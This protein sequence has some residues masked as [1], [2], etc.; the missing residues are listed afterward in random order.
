MKRFLAGML[1][2]LLLLAIA[3]SLATT[4][5]I[6]RVEMPGNANAAGG[7]FRRADVAYYDHRPVLRSG[8]RTLVWWG[9]RDGE[10]RRLEWRSSQGN[11]GTYYILRD[12]A[13][14]SAVGIERGSSKQAFFQARYDK[15]RRDYDA[16][17]IFARVWTWRTGRLR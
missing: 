1:A 11:R 13:L 5:M 16:Q 12:K 9:T 3:Y 17:S 15:L 8:D 10:W 4:P 14:G 2:F 7:G 6:E